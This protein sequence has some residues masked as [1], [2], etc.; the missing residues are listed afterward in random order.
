MQRLG[1]GPE[2]DNIRR[3][4]QQLKRTFHMRQQDPSTARPPKQL[5]D[6]SHLTGENLEEEGMIDESAPRL[7]VRPIE[8]CGRC[9][10]GW[11]R[12]PETR[13]SV[14]LCP[15]C[16]IPRRKAKRLNDLE[17][18]ADAQG[19]H[20]RRYEWDT[21][22]QEHKITSMLNHIIEPQQPHAPCSFLWGAPG[23]G[24][25]SLLYGVARWASFRNKRVLFT[26]HTQIMNRIKD[27]WGEKQKRDPLRGWLDRCD[28]L[29]LDELG[30]LG[31]KAQRS[32][33]YTATTI[34][35][36]G[37]MYER[38]AGGKLAIVMT[39]NLNPREVAQL[40]ERNGAVMS[41]LNAMFGAPIQM[42]GDDRRQRNNPD[43]KAWG[44]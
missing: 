36:V 41:R 17:L 33:W 2:F 3:Q 16:E 18:P 30:G 9:D 44:L 13:N 5:L 26:S 42:V 29:L 38:W 4:A 25:T 24:K 43:L 10:E 35:I 22:T 14:R 8:F 7:T 23:N 20:L 32:S 1:S 6:Y 15:F 37:A 28:V 27:T 31:G 39:S 19:M 34:E 11:L 40:F 12:I 21:P